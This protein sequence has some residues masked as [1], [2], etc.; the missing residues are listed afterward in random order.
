MDKDLIRRRFAK[1]AGSYAGEA[2]MQ[3]HVARHMAA[4]LRSCLPAQTGWDVLE[5][6]CGTGMFTREYLRTARP[7]HLLLNDICPEV[8]PYLADVLASPGTRFQ[9]CDAEPLP[10]PAGQ[11]LVASCSAIQWLEHPGRFL[12]R[13]SDLL[14]EGGYLAFSTFGPQNVREVATLTQDTLPYRSLQTWRGL[15]TQAYEVVYCKEETLRQTFPSPLHVLKHLKA[16]GVTGIRSRQWTKG[17]LEDFSRRY[18]ERNSTPDGEVT[19][20]YHPIYMI[21]KKRKR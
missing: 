13:C 3:R 12:C 9:A 20:T 17:Q 6:G 11:N 21:C 1:A 7:A 16:T 18:R 5:I 19:L 14:S 4:A 8:A 2:R 10:F 15:L